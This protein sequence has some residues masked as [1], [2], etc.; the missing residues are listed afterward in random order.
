MTGVTD[1]MSDGADV[2]HGGGDR[3]SGLRDPAAAVRGLGAGTL[4]MEAVVLL[5]A[6]QPIRVLGGRLSGAGVAAV[7][8][9]AVLA[10]ALAGLIR[11]RWAWPAGGVLQALLLLAGFLHWSLGVL[12]IIFA[13]AWWYATHVRRTILG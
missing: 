3:P 11:R 6:I 8:G 2:P 4:V 5:L 10:L 1:P 13:A 12:G 9:L 7:V